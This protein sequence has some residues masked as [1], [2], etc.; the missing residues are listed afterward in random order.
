[1]PADE[2]MPPAAQSG[3]AGAGYFNVHSEVQASTA[4]P[5]VETLDDLVHGCLVRM[6]P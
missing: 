5:L 1:M 3:M 4:S 6:Q 2:T